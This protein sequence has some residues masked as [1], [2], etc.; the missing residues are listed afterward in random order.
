M[1]RILISLC[2]ACSACYITAQKPVTSLLN[3]PGTFKKDFI[4]VDRGK[5]KANTPAT[6]QMIVKL[7]KYERH[8]DPYQAVMLIDGV[9]NYVPLNRLENYFQTEFVDKNS[10]WIL[11]QLRRIRDNKEGDDYSKLR[12]EQTKDAE[13]YL[14]ELERANLFY[15]DAAIEDYLQCLL[16]SIVPDKLINRKELPKPIIRLLKSA[17]PDMMLLGNDALLISTGMLAM[18]D[19]EDEMLALLTR[20]V[21]H[22][23]FDHSLITIKKNIIR[24]NRAAFWG[25]I[26]DGVV[27]ATERTL[28]ERYDYYEPGVLFATNDLIQSLVNQ[29]IYNR[30][31]LDYSKEQEMEADQLA[32]AFLERM[33]K[34]KDALASALHK[35][36]DYY[37]REGDMDALHK[38]G[39]YGT[40]AKRLEKLDKP[41]PMPKDRNFL[42]KMM[43]I[44]SFEAAMQDY[45]K[46]YQNARFWAMKNID[47]GLACPDDY[48]MVARSLMK[49]SNTPESNAESLLYL[50]KAELVSEV[51]NLNITKMRIL[52]K[53][54]DN[55]QVE[56][57]DLLLKYKSQLDFMYQQPHTA[58]DD[59]WIAAEYQWADKLLERIYIL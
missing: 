39:P 49:Q 5:I 57:V 38:Y 29:N 19:S 53:L 33:G 51:E 31:G 27:E 26:A 36:N 48:L 10:F 45:N 58:E 25:A 59:E 43:S 28:Y 8:E 15:N 55:K 23:I 47:N 11:A 40:L 2:L 46:H 24:A 1:K 44:V 56:A 13:K 18:L 37:L 52:L 42:K 16:L 32:I 20:E 14:E 9:Q 30:M 6:L 7:K 3:I 34:S 54:R 35:M 22:H 21:V 4:P 12:W 41:E 17:S 50:D